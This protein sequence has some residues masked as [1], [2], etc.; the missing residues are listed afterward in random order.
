ML[1][2]RYLFVTPSKI[3]NSVRRASFRTVSF[4]LKL[5]HS[6]VQLRAPRTNIRDVKEKRSTCRHLCD[7]RPLINGTRGGSGIR[8]VVRHDEC[9]IGLIGP[10]S[11][12]PGDYGSIFS[13]EGEK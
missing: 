1:S 5:N 7:G 6:T 13:Y 10:N 9:V 11:R 8:G 4:L 2:A 3:N 12:A